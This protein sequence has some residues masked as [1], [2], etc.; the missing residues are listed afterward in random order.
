MR[1]KQVFSLI[2]IAA[3][4]LC[5]SYSC[6]AAAKEN[7]E[8]PSAGYTFIFPDIP[9]NLSSPQ[10]R[11][12]YLIA[13]YWDNFDFTA[14]YSKADAFIEQTL[15]DFLSILPI[16]ESEDP[17]VKAFEALITKSAVNEKLKNDIGRLIPIYLGNT[18]SPMRND[19]LYLDYLEVW[20][21]QP[22]LD[23]SEKMRK[24]DLIEMLSKNM[25]GT[26]ATDFTYKTIDGKV[27]T[28][29]S[30]LSPGS[31]MLLMFFNPN[32]D[33]CE[34]AIIEMENSQ[35]LKKKIIDGELKI[36][37]VYS[38]DNVK[39][40]KRKAAA[41]PENWTIGINENEIEESDLYYLPGLPSFYLIGADGIIKEKEMPLSWIL[42]EK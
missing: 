6:N 26:Q 25:K 15:V 34:G 13:H 33:S 10:D 12:E 39:E 18:D 23:R 30:T 35:Y 24:M 36:L 38:G 29:S 1:I 9:N 28:M 16:I 19:R 5:A 8:N 7:K 2:F 11:A 22:D 4:I 37:A 20:T 14:D 32:C 41:M 17:V 21:S 42:G 40:W 3:G 31:D 27:H